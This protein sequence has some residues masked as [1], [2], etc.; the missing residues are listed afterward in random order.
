MSVARQCGVKVVSAMRST[1]LPTKR[2]QRFRRLSASAAVVVVVIFAAV[3]GG[4]GC[5]NGGG[6]VQ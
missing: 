5:G 2:S 6:A 3:G 4:D 1:V